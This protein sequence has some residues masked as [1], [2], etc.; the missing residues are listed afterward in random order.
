MSLL[1]HIQNI[2]QIFLMIHGNS[3]EY[4]LLFGAVKYWYTQGPELIW[5]FSIAVIMEFYGIISV[6]LYDFYSYSYSS[7]F[8]A[9]ITSFTPSI[10]YSIHSVLDAVL[11][12]KGIVLSKID[13]CSFPWPYITIGKDTNDKQPGT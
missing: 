12:M 5:Y 9:I 8:E 13:G 4:W 6:V 10:I 7:F 11:H 3:Y 2:T 1:Q